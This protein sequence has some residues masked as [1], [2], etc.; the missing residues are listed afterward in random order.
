[1]GESGDGDARRR[2]IQ[3]LLN[4][5]WGRRWDGEGYQVREEVGAKRE[6][7]WPWGKYMR[8]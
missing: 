4:V 3:Q 1:V 5:I 2:V 6:E 7:P 8:V